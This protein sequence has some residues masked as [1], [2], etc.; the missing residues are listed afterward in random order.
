M[1]KLEPL[2]HDVTIRMP[3]D[4]SVVEIKVGETLVTAKDRLEARR[5]TA[6]PDGD[7]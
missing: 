4:S 5:G 3:P 1:V 7:V 2:R 6:R